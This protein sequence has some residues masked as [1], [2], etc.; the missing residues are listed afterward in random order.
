MKRQKKLSAAIAL[1]A[2]AIL[3]AAMLAACNGVSGLGGIEG[4]GS[5]EK[6][7]NVEFS[8]SAEV[9]GDAPQVVRLTLS[10][11]VGMSFELKGTTGFTLKAGT[12][13]PANLSKEK[14]PNGIM[15]TLT[16][17]SGKPRTALLQL[18]GWIAYEDKDLVL[19]YDASAG[20][21]YSNGAACNSFTIPVT[22]LVA[23]TT[24]GPDA[25]DPNAPVP[26]LTKATVYDTAPKHI[27]LNF[28]VPVI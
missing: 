4:L 20:E 11:D 15:G 28:N 18:D 8:G 14:R 7:P 22:N 23:E 6:L 25:P 27:K 26:E 5:G 19:S 3:A 12:G 1:S 16:F 17:E 24:T 9:R 2:A 10:S 13:D 21:L